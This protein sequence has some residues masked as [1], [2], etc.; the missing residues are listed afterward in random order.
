[1]DKFYYRC[2]CVFQSVLRLYEVKSQLGV[3]A[4]V[5]SQEAWLLSR[6][7]ELKEEVRRGRD[8]EIELVIQRLEEETSGARE[9]CE[10]AA[11]NRC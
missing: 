4:C 11:D 3:T 2:V 7:R 5:C 9:E 8:K 6:E 10:R 1:M